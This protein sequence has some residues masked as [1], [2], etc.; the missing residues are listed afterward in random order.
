MLYKAPPLA[1][2]SSISMLMKLMTGAALA[3]A[4][5][6]GATPAKAQSFQSAVETF[7]NDEFRANPIAATD[8]GVH[9]Y[10][11]E[12]DDLSRDGQSKNAARLHK[13]LD[14]LTAI[15]PATLSA[16]DATIARC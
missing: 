7:Y 9:E 4:V 3:A 14:A 2:G 16:G 10:D 5:L 13:A 6:A 11:A 1:I 15:D 8:I 12:V